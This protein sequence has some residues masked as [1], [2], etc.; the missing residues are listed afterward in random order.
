M[1]CVLICVT[2]CI[3]V[4]KTDVN[5]ILMQGHWGWGWFDTTC[6]WGKIRIPALLNSTSLCQPF[7][8]LQSAGIHL[9]AVCLVWKPLETVFFCGKLVFQSAHWIRQEVKQSMDNDCYKSWSA[10]HM[11][12]HDTWHMYHC[13]LVKMRFA[14]TSHVL[15]CLLACLF[16]CWFVAWFLFEISG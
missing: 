2:L 4:A 5:Y 10:L 12:V 14:K 3:Y 15:V 6:T 8:P 9:F 13:R 7:R 16:V 1:V 11:D